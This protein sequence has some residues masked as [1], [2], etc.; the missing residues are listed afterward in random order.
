MRLDLGAIAK[1][2]AVDKAVEA[3]QKS[4]AA[5]GLVDAGGN[6]RCF[7]LPPQRKDCWL[8]GL[9][10]PHKPE[11]LYGMSQP[12]LVLRLDDA[13]VA[14]SGGYR[15]F[16]VIADKKY[17]H[18]IDP[19]SPGAAEELKSV[20]IIA[21][22]AVDADAISTAVYVMGAEKGIALVRS[23]TGTEA[24]LVTCE[25]EYKI[26]KSNGADKFVEQ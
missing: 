9:Q 21:E 3:M 26:I 5:G 24:I 1:G 4:G 20:T 13:A 2:Y 7:G 18:I 19:R 11:E 16:V 25:P 6:I 8:V 10:D 14:T 23:M 15:R 12:L 22:K 17:S